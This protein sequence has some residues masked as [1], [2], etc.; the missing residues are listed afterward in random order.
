[1]CTA[2]DTPGG[3]FKGVKATGAIRAMPC[4]GTYH[5]YGPSSVHEAAI[6]NVQNRCGPSNVAADVGTQIQSTKSRVS[7]KQIRISLKKNIRGLG[8]RGKAPGRLARDQLRPGTGR[9]SRQHVESFCPTLGGSAHNVAGT[10][11]PIRVR[12]C[13][14][15]SQNSVCAQSLPPLEGTSPAP[16][17]DQTDWRARHSRLP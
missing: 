9:W 5:P 3:G 10:G 7:D 4:I 11:Q 14:P 2:A 15:A 16:R 6:G 1:M 12:G 8:E 13:C 17:G